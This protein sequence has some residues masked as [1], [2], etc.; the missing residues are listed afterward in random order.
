MSNKTTQLTIYRADTSG[1]K[2][3]CF[4]P[5]EVHVT[6]REGLRH[7]LHYDHVFAKFQDNR[8]GNEYFRYADFLV[9]DCDNDH[10][11]REEEWI[12]PEDLA[13]FLPDVKFITYTSRHHDMAKESKSARPRFHVIF[14]IAHTESADEYAMMKKKAQALLPFFDSN[15]LD[16]GRFFYGVEDPEIFA[17]QGEK[18]LTEWMQEEEMSKRFG[19]DAVI[20]EGKRNSMLS[21]IAGRL[22][23]RF[24]DTN[25]AYEAFMKEAERCSPPL[26]DKEISRIWKSAQKYYLTVSAQP[27]YIPP[28]QYGLVKAT[29]WEEPIPLSDED[30]LPG[31]PVDTLP[32]VIAAYVREVAKTLQI[33]ADMAASCTL[34]VLSTCLQ[35][36]FEVKIN[37]T[38]KEPINLYILIVAEPSEKKSPCI[39][40]M[41]SP[42]AEYEEAWNSEHAAAIRGSQEM[43]LALEVSVEN[44]RKEVAKGRA[45]QDEL[46]EAVNRE[47]AFTPQKELRLYLDDVT[48][49]KLVSE[50]ADNGG[51][52]AII[53][54]EGGVFDNFAGRYSGSANIDVLL[55]AY[56]GDTIKKDRATKRNERIFS[57]AL[58]ILDMMQPNALAGIMTNKIFRER[59]LTARILYC[60]PKSLVG[61]R[62]SDPETVREETKEAYEKLVISL[63][64]EE[65]GKTETI[66]L[67]EEAEKERIA[68]DRELER[69]QRDEYIDFRD[70]IGKIVGTTIRI[71]ALLYLASEERPAG[72]ES[73]EPQNYEIS[74]EFMRKAILIARYYIQ[75]MIMAYR[76]AGME[77]MTR[78]CRKALAALVRN[79]CA[80]F[81]VRD[82]MRYCKFKTAALAQ[83]VVDHLEDLGYVKPQNPEPYRKPGRPS[84]SKYT[85]NPALLEE[86][87]T[88]A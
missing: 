49:E 65:H 44:I 9:L 6:D 19:L 73:T 88:S 85:L 18:D 43:K 8:R 37:S 68:F 71:A 33:P 66:T 10:S 14:P 50:I 26:P 77:T 42:I 52:C 24:G 55:K 70:W 86:E 21:G 57:P 20:P 54:S 36:K 46:Q 38:W 39:K 60:I 7:A 64:S 67:S 81:T 11:D 56:S 78:N 22:I 84:G 25:E 16:A 79:N 62:D 1:N 58:T 31:F 23:K 59:G 45:T 4:Y 41:S 82:L 76:N 5:H 3:N 15:A 75:H 34:G 83:A 51:A 53:S 29:V 80:E 2:Q 12:R 32:P 61:Y 27:G 40:L 13:E 63:L 74:G 17:H 30:D 48:P 28:E 47:L 35:K 69:K 87:L 72:N